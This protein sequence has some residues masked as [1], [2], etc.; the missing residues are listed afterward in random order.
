STVITGGTG[1]T[2]DFNNFTVNKSGSGVVTLSTNGLDVDGTLT[3]TAGVL[4]L[5]G[6]N[7]TT[8]T[9]FSNNGTLRL[10]GT[11]TVSWT[12][13]DTDSGTF[14]YVGTANSTANPYT[15][16]DFTGT[17]YYNL[18]LNSTDSGVNADTFISASS[19]TIAGTLTVTQGTYSANTNS[20][21][22]TGFTTV[23]GGTYLASSAT[24]TFNAGLTVSS[25]TFTGST[26]TVDVNGT[27][28]LSGGTLTAPSGE[29]QVSGDWVHSSGTFTHN[30]GTVKLD[31]NDQTISGAN[32][33]NNLTK[34]VT[35]S[36]TLTFPTGIGNEQVILGTLTLHGATG[37]LLILA[38]S[39]GGVQWR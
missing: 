38:P 17:D 9:T 4:S 10:Q 6:Q 30:S 18:L 5:N 39:T 8:T 14:E 24:Q 7:I 26:G 15:I 13:N 1:A 20:T 16:L 23:G 32:T 31:G 29:L 35:T 36:H 25:G 19:K 12:T 28:T 3:I 27:L 22:V 33:F 37:Q 11:E 34:T 2:Q 21:T